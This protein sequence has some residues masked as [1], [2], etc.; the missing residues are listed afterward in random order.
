MKKPSHPSGRAAYHPYYDYAAFFRDAGPGAQAGAYRIVARG[1]GYQLIYTDPDIGDII[2]AE[3][4]DRGTIHAAY[5]RAVRE[6]ITRPPNVAVDVLAPPALMVDYGG[7]PSSRVLGRYHV[8]DTLPVGDYV[9]KLHKDGR[10]SC[11]CSQWKFHCAKAG[12]N[13]KH[14]EAAGVLTPARDQRDLIYTPVPVA[15]PKMAPEKKAGFGGVMLAHSW[16]DQDPTGWW[17]SEKLDG[18]RAYWDGHGLFSRNGNP[19]YTPEWFLAG[20]PKQVALDGELWLGRGHF[21]DLVSITRSQVPDERWKNVKYLVFALPD[22]GLPFVEQIAALGK[23]P[24]SYVDGPPTRLGNSIRKVTWSPVE[25]VQCRNLA[26]LKSY[27]KTIAAEGGEGVMLRRGASP[28]ER[29]RSHELL[30]VKDFLDGEAEV[31]G[32]YAGEGKHLGRIGG[33]HC[34]LLANDALFDVGTGLSDHDREHPLKRGTIITVKYQNLSD[35]GNPRF[36]VFVAVRNYE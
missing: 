14:I 26:H 20:L 1:K 25:Q 22:S 13:C 27:H 11:T 31:L 30:K 2:L 4:P 19:V 10:W 33:Y 24:R 34:R 8:G 6:G 18:M 3:H 9:I 16:K 36:P 17:M 28:Y 21:Q 35:A 5:K 29:R 23:M 12:T 32:T 15:P 7:S